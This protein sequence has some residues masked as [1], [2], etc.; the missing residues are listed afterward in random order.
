MAGGSTSSS[1]GPEAADVYGRSP[2]VQRLWFF[3]EGDR[4]WSFDA[5]ISESHTSEL[6]V[7]ENPVETGV[8][9][10]DH[11]FMAPLRLEIE[12]A[13]G[14]AWMD[15]KGSDGNRVSDLW[16]SPAGRAVTAFTMLQN[17]Q[18]SAIPF[19]VQTGL[20]LYKDMLISSLSAEQNAATSSILRFRASLRQVQFVSTRDV[21]APQRAA[22][23]TALNASKKITRGQAQ[24]KP[25]TEPAQAESL[26][27]SL[28]TPEQKAALK[29]SGAWGGLI[30]S[31]VP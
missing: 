3:G 2:A 31:L 7:T 9:I 21:V 13:I 20:K 16:A 1:T 11:A 12:A 23:K 28:L 24:A 19:S 17:L 6:T 30:K 18:R 4:L 26:L 29:S 22:G 27:A 14:D 8:V 5:V 10:S 15:A 25:V